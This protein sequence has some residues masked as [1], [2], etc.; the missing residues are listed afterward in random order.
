MADATTNAPRVEDLKSVGTRISWGAVLAGTV[1][2]LALYVVL[3]ALGAAIGFSIGRDMSYKALA[4]GALV[5]AIL[6]VGLSLFAGGWTTSQLTAG[7]TKCES[8]VHGV[9][10]WGTVFAVMLGMM[11]MGIRSGFG[12]MLNIAYA[13]DRVADRGDEA[14]L[15][16]LGFSEQDLSEARERRATATA[17]EWGFTQEQIDK[18]RAARDDAKQKIKETVASTDPDAVRRGIAMTTWG[19]VFGMIL[20]MGAAIAGALVGAGPSYRLLWA[21]RPP[22]ERVTTERHY[23]S[24]I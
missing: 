5:W 9:I 20:S 11:G 2:A 1:V 10:L 7:E 6:T 8:M 21:G 19:A 17:K 13:G 22:L 16:D 18:A 14:T 12:A 15:R 23:A 4:N 24:Q 3:T